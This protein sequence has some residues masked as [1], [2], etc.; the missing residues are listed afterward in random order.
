MY[1]NVFY[2]RDEF[3]LVVET[4]D[5]TISQNPKSPKINTNKAIRIINKKFGNIP[6][7]KTCQFYQTR[8]ILF[9]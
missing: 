9:K 6:L 5:V 2:L 8:V 3:C 7:P 1:N 4:M